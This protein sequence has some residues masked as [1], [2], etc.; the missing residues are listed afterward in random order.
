MRPIGKLTQEILAQNAGRDLD[1]MILKCATMRQ[2]AFAFF[3]GTNALF[4]SFLPRA[5]AVFR[6]PCT[7]GRKKGNG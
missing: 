7:L 6:A 1:R 2:D 5:H 3:R 4:L